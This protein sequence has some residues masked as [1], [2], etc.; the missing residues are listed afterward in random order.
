[1]DFIFFKETNLPTDCLLRFLV[2]THTASPQ[3]LLSRLFTQGNKDQ[4]R[5][6]N[7]IARANECICDAGFLNNDKRVLKKSDDIYPH[8]PFATVGCKTVYK[9]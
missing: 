4:N 9:M 3:I 6:K 2:Q 5:H 8:T 1:M 7:I